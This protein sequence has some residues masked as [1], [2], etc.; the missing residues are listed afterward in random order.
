[1][2]II[3]WSITWQTSL[4][5]HECTLELVPIYSKGATNHSSNDLEQGL[6]PVSN[7][8]A[9]SCFF[10]ILQ[11]SLYASM[12]DLQDSKGRTSQGIYSS[13]HQPH[14][15][16][17]CAGSDTSTV[18]GDSSEE[19]EGEEEGGIETDARDKGGPLSITHQQ[20]QQ[21]Q[22][23]QQQQ[24]QQQSPQ[25]ISSGISQ[26][27]PL[28][29]KSASMPE[30]DALPTRTGSSNVV[31][32]IVPGSQMTSSPAT[33]RRLSAPP[34]GTPPG[35]SPAVSRKRLVYSQRPPS[36]IRGDCTCAFYEWNPM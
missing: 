19:S 31:S 26:K 6:K 36:K 10:S 30:E 12:S 29:Y 23:N 14:Y 24:Q 32:S 25:K 21:Q 35:A 8:L 22:R 5:N 4:P 2:T 16:I 33:N 11:L 13:L 1:M 15:E 3:L 9:Y 20:Q 18:E 28:K 7:Q 27:A 17:H 34:P